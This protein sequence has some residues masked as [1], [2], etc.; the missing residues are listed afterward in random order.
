[1]NKTSA[2]AFQTLLRQ[3]NKLIPSVAAS[4]NKHS[5]W[6]HA[7]EEASRP[8]HGAGPFPLSK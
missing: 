1:M 7:E 6:R 2:S 8:Q 4:C 5:G 3:K